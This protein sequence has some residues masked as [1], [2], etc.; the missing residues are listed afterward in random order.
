MQ[1]RKHLEFWKKKIRESFTLTKAKIVFVISS[2]LERNVLF[3]SSQSA[4]VFLLLYTKNLLHRNDVTIMQKLC[5]FFFRPQ[6]QLF[7]SRFF[8]PILSFAIWLVTGWKPTRTSSLEPPMCFSANGSVLL[9]LI[10]SFPL[11]W[12]RYFCQQYLERK[13]KYMQ[14]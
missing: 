12:F 10:K 6:L 2:S 14:R 11:S 4:K 7:S 3:H 8:F 13:K 9:S 5:N 1:N